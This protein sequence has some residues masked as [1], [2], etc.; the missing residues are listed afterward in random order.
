MPRYTW[1][2]EACHT[3]DD[4]IVTYEQR[5]DW[6]ACSKCG[7][8][9]IRQFPF[10]AVRGIRT[11]EPHYDEGLG[12][13]VNDASEKRAIMADMGV[14][15]AG[16]KKGGAR[17]FDE[18]APFKVGKQPLRGAKYIPRSARVHDD[19]MVGIE[20]GGKVSEVV[21]MSQLKSV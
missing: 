7:C 14:H 10:E 2:C 17:N 19:M 15:E 4:H 8:P 20:K 13:D 1:K 9:T 6:R 3:E 5:D 18:K 21:P 16:D 12:C 11:F